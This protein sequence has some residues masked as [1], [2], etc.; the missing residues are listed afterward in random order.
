MRWSGVVMLALLGP[1]SIAQAQTAVTAADRADIQALVAGYARALGGCAAAEFA[2][3]FVPGSGYFA[4]GFRGQV[5]GRERLVALV[6]SERHCLAAPGA[7]PAARP[8]S[9]P[10]VA[11]ESTAAGVR[12]TVDLGAAGHY[13]DEYAKTPQGWR[14]AARHVVT[15]GEQ[16]AGLSSH[17][18][19]EISRLAGSAE[20]G[21]L[22]VSGADG[23]RRFRSSGVVLGLS[24]D[25]ITGR[26]LLKD[27]GGSYDDVYV[28]T[29]EGRWR[30]KS[31]VHVAAGQQPQSQPQ[32]QPQ[33]PGAAAPALTA[34]DY[35]EIQHLVS[36]YALYID[37]CSN[38]GY[39][40]ADLFAPD[41]F[42]APEQGGKIGTK[43]QGR[44]QLAAVSGG[45]SRGCKN[46]GWI[47][48]GVKHI[49]VNHIITPAADGAT[50]TVDM[51]MIGL[52]NDPFRIR[53]EGYY[54][55]SYVKTAQ[56]WKF[57]SRIH[58]VPPPSAVPP[59]AVPPPAVPPAGPAPLAPV[60]R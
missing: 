13:E 59:P 20:A 18:M 42:F 6:Q 39:D 15:P 33:R 34:L 31:R 29:P 45:G 22:Y 26:V 41:G 54:E 24:A 46:V 51:L 11:I 10:T 14:F 44:E 19:V 3:L 8:N 60:Q 32:S 49:Y 28:K 53:H 55:D 48:Q 23:V 5:V 30:F 9:V 38:N 25:G 35:I 12:G 56:G 4:S 21:D 47:V 43:F 37:T 27:G 52:N 1:A 36:K 58:H 7:A 50:G 17:D 2:D 16:K 57:R 40:Y